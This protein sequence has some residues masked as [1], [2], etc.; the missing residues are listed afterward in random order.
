MG[1]LAP[2]GVVWF[3]V[4]VLFDNVYICSVGVSIWAVHVHTCTD[5]LVLGELVASIYLLFVVVFA[6]D[7]LVAGFQQVQRSLIKSLFSYRS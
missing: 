2:S 7:C 5:C 6:V 3:N 4:C 1:T